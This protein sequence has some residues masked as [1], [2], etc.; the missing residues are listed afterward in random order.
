MVERQET[1]AG[2]SIHT[3]EV[4]LSVP[5]GEADDDLGITGRRRGLVVNYARGGGNGGEG[6][7][8]ISYAARI[9]QQ[10]DGEIFG[11]CGFV[12]YSGG[13]AYI[14]NVEGANQNMR[15]ESRALLFAAALGVGGD[16]GPTRAVLF[17]V[18]AMS[19]ESRDYELYDRVESLRVQ[20]GSFPFV[21]TIG[22]SL[23]MG[24]LFGR[25][26]WTKHPDRDGVASLGA[27]LSW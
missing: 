20:D 14:V 19:S 6:S 15:I 26:T 23:G 9:F 10:L 1:Q 7:K 8:T 17:V 24:P 13:K 16:L 21:W 18:P 2:T 3:G 25:V 5:T 11:L 22:A 27:G 12:G 4:G